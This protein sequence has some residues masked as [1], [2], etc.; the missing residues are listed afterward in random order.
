M[1]RV[2]IRQLDALAK[3]T[4]HT[5]N[6]EQRR[7]LMAQADIILHSSASAIP[8]PS[9][10]AAVRRRYDDLVAVQASMEAAPPF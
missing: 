7:A 6:D 8:E 10:V 9:D 4:G 1:P 5:R 3:V 2:M